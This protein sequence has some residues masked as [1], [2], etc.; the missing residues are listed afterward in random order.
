MVKQAS[1]IFLKSA[2][3]STAQAP[4]L[5]RLLWRKALLKHKTSST[6]HSKA[7]QL[8]AYKWMQTMSFLAN[9]ISQLI[10]DNQQYLKLHLHKK[11][12]K[13]TLAKQLAHSWSFLN[14]PQF[15]DQLP[16]RCMRCHQAWAHECS[17]QARCSKQF[18]WTPPALTIALHGTYIRLVCCT[19]TW[20]KCMYTTSTS[21]VPSMVTKN[22]LT[23]HSRFLSLVWSQRCY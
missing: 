21:P 2:Y 11:Q 10:I 17:C 8:T 9:R 3:T 7:K 4:P 20:V 19:G 18:Q 12:W 15:G 6:A 13:Y 23:D 1:R 5:P 22:V 16:R 14:G